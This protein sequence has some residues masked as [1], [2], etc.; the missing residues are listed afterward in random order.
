MSIYSDAVNYLGH[1]DDF[2][3]VADGIDEFVKAGNAAD[4]AAAAGKISAGVSVGIL[5]AAA[6][7]SA[8]SGIR[9]GLAVAG[10]IDRWEALSKV[11]GIGA[12]MSAGELI[13]WLNS[14]H[15]GSELY[16]FL[17]PSD[18]TANNFSNA[19]RFVPRYDP[20][21]LD[22]NNNGIETIAPNLTNPFYST[23]MATASRVALAGLHPQMA[24][25]YWTATATG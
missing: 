19:Q 10:K 9:L 25:S 14:L 13:D 11:L 21:T 16:D 17:H 3:T 5:T 24:S 12:G 22:L 4:M 7:R 23:T 15:L 8:F 2:K 20:L 6:L 1:F 18:A